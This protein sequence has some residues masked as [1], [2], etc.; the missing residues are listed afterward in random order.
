MKSFEADEGK[1]PDPYQ[2]GRN[3]TN[4]RVTIY[5]RKEEIVDDLRLQRE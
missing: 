5:L 4:T 1:P 3:A 2:P